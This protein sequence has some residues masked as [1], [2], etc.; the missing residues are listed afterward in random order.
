MGIYRQG[1]KYKIG[2]WSVREKRKRVF[3]GEGKSE[4]LILQILEETIK[5]RFL[6]FV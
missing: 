2:G 6:L 5:N 4:I 3:E 1:Q